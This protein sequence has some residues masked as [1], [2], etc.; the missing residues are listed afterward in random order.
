MTE[1]CERY[2]P[3]WH[4]ASVQT[5]PDRVQVIDGVAIPIPEHPRFRY[6]GKQWY[7]ETSMAQYIALATFPHDAAQSG[8]IRRREWENCCAVAACAFR[9]A[10]NYPACE[11]WEA[12]LA[13]AEGKR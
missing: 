7:W 9:R 11:I 4:R 6:V 8:G 13:K 1:M 10:C 5:D 12:A 2:D 3:T